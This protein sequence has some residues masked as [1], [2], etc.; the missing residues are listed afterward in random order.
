[1]FCI[2]MDKATDALFKTESAT[3]FLVILSEEHKTS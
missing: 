1:M 2:V 3:C